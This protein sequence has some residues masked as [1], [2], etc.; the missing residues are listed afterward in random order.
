ML[1]KKSEVR[2]RRLKNM[3][4]LRRFLADVTNR[5]N[6]DEID[7]A[8]AGKLGYLCQI[9]A[10]IIESGDLEKR[11]TYIEETIKNQGGIKF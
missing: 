5:L 7:P 10:R 3:E 11:L 6:C 2:K 4:D 9:L 8:K 1:S